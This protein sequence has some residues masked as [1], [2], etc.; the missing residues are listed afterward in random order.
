MLWPSNALVIRNGSTGYVLAADNILKA[1][2]RVARSL[3]GA[4]QKHGCAIS[5]SQF[6]AV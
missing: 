4:Q 5:S 3:L 1:R 6:K 2:S